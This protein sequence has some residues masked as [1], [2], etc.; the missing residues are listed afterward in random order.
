MSTSD[1]ASFGALLR[2]YR[3]AAHLTQKQLAERV[4]MSSRSI[5]ALEH[6]DRRPP[7]AATAALMANALNLSYTERAA[8]QAAVHSIDPTAGA[9]ASTHDSDARRPAQSQRRHVPWLP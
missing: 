2:R 4:G 1:F 9:S 3:V 8:F 6:G 5:A 7:P